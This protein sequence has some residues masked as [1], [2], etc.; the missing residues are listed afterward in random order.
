MR[1]GPATEA[2]EGIIFVTGIH[3]RDPSAP[4]QPT[5]RPTETDLPAEQ[6]YPLVTL[7]PRPRPPCAERGGGLGF[8]VD[9]PP[10]QTLI[11][12]S[13]FCNRTPD[14]FLK[15]H[16]IRGGTQPPLKAPN[17]GLGGGL[18]YHGLE[19]VRAGPHHLVDLVPVLVDVES[20]HG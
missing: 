2:G 6:P 5:D 4:R 11:V 14:F 12:L 10:P 15:I 19:L 7:Q 17:L 18:L 20:G 8:G 9:F 3:R 16:T 13:S 1:L